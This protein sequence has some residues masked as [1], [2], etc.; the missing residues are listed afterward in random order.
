M[1]SDAV[2]AAFFKTGQIV[3]SGEEAR[4][5]DFATVVF[6]SEPSA[7]P[8]NG[9]EVEATPVRNESVPEV[10]LVS[11]AATVTVQFVVPKLTTAP[12]ALPAV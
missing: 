5:D 10:A 7:V 9:V 4:V 6:E 2:P 12:A 11:T 1:D 8:L 3:N